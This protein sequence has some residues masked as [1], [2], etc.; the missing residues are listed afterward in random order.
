M[1]RLPL[2]VLLVVFLASLCGR[3]GIETIVV[4]VA[5][6]LLVT[7]LVTTHDVEVVCLAEVLVVL[8]VGSVVQVVL[9]F[10]GE[11]IVSIV[12][13]RRSP[14]LVV[15]SLLTVS[16]VAAEVHVQAQVFQSVDLVVNL[17]VALIVI[18][19]GFVFFLVEQ[20]YGVGTCKGNLLIRPGCIAVG[21]SFR[22][23]PV[24]VELRII[25]VR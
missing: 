21:T 15:G 18:R 10:L 6:V 3:L 25:G 12:E 8:D 7:P 9:V 19:V 4:G 11:A 23:L 22:P 14:R 24:V 1:L 16:P 17:H 13:V 5:P 2:V 20:R